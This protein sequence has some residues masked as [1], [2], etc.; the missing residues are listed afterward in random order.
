MRLVRR[1]GVV[2]SARHHCGTFFGE[3]CIDLEINGYLPAEF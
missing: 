2:A 3:I 1:A